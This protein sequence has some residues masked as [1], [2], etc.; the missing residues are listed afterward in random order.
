MKGSAAGPGWLRR[1]GMYGGAALAFVFVALAL[2]DQSSE[3]DYPDPEREVRHIMPWRAGGGTDA[4]MRAFMRYFEEHLGVP[5]ITENIS[6]GVS[7][8]GLHTV[9]NAA[10]DGYTVGT[11]TYDALT[12]GVLGLAPVAWTDFAPIC[13]VTEHPSALI[14]RS[15]RWQALASFR[16]EAAA[17]PGRVRVGNAGA[18]GVWHQHA[19]ALQRAMGIRLHHIPYEASGALLSAILGGEVDAVVSSLPAFLPYVREGTLTVLGV[20]ATE[21]DALIPDAPTFVEQGYDVTYGSFRS[22]I[23]PLQTPDSILAHLEAV[24]RAA[25]IDPEFQDW[26]RDAAAGPVW[27]N[28]EETKAYLTALEPEVRQLM[29]QLGMRDPGQ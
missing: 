26:A 9:K 7:A 5:V 16:A 17:D 1:L 6:G 29:E 19:M 11:M 3:A 27:R 15:D 2:P 12:V 22:V 23:A 14:G 8:I 20:M 21:R 4:A 24:C 10:P 18:R 13:T 28:R 25:W